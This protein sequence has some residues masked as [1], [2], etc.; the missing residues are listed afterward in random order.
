MQFLCPNCNIIS[1]ISEIK[2]DEEKRDKA[3]VIQKEI[4]D[5]ESQIKKEESRWITVH[6][7]RSLRMDVLDK[8]IKKQECETECRYVDCPVCEN[9]NYIKDKKR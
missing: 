9:R 3:K 2:V 4:E 6:F 1:E 7:S 5:L 8:I